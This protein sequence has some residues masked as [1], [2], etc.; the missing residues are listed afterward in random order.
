MKYVIIGSC[1]AAAGA[2]EGIRSVDVEGPITI[3]DGEREGSYTRPLISYYLADPDKHETI[4]YRSRAFFDSHG[5]RIIAARAAKIEIERGIVVLD[6]GNE[7]TYDRLLLATGAAPIV[8]PISGAEHPWVRT[9]Y[10]LEDVRYLNEN[11]LPEQNVV[12]IGT[13]LIGMKAAEAFHKRGLKVVMVEK[14]LHILPR[15]LNAG[16]AAFAASHLTEQGI[17]MITGDEV[18]SIHPDHQVE[19]KS[20]LMLPADLV[21]MAVGTRPCAELARKAGLEVKQGIAVNQY[22]QTSDQN[23]FAAGDVI[24]T[25]NKMSGKTEVMALLP[26][27]HREGYLAGCNMAGK[28]SPY[29]G[30]IF[31]NSVKLMGWNICSA[32]NPGEDAEKCLYYEHQEQY[33]QLFIQNGCLVRYIAINLPEAVGPLTHVVEKQIRVSEAGWQQFI[34]QGAKLSAVPPE[35]WMEIR[36]ADHYGTSQ[37]G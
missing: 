6:N 10:T 14:D 36:R 31:M 37:C 20:G 13:G 21:I 19:L 29:P 4:D 3:I 16:A 22:L 33:L 18:T 30:G 2:V 5:A 9:F 28:S 17:S 7:I 12:V 11:I 35:Y 25:L 32:G 34:D 24:E 26:H 23:I 15:Q 1:I 8:P 27:A